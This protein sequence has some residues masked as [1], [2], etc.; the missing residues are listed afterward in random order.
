MAEYEDHD[1]PERYGPIPPPKSDDW[2]EFAP[3]DEHSDKPSDLR[4]LPLLDMARLASHEPPKRQWAVP[5]WIPLLQA[6]Y[7]TGP[8]SAGKSLLTQQ[9]CT[10]KALGGRF[11]GVDVD[12]APALY[13]TCEDDADE[14]ERRQKDIC[15][16]LGT[17]RSALVDKLYLCSLQ[18]EIGNQLVTF[19]GDGQ[20]MLTDAYR[21]LEATAVDLGIRFI[22]L[23]N[24]AHL[25]SEE[26]ERS[27]VAAF[28]NLLNRLSLR[29]GGSVLLL[30][31]PNKMGQ[32]YS[33]STAWENQV[34]S[35]LFMEEPKPDID[36]DLKVLRRAKSNYSRKGEEIEFRWHQGAFVK[37][38]DLP[39][40]EAGDLASAAAAAAYNERFLKCLAEMT[41]QHRHVSEKPGAN[42]A[43]KV[44]ERMSEAKGSSK[45]DMQAA[46][47]RL[48]RLDRIER[49]D[50]WRGPDRKPV[51]GLR[52]TRETPRVA[53]Q[54]LTVDNVS[55]PP[56]P[57]AGNH[58]AD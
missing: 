9:L 32:E 52:E 4:P 33:G 2:R 54:A 56:I 27:K 8:G 12:Q 30:G 42:Y 1:W 50:L 20:M 53:E 19:R 17:P 3:A 11:L 28:V 10:C 48:F 25:T 24:V 58:A 39:P 43:P 37:D 6:T 46:M 31:H 41:R 18:G 55:N 22:V 49:A 47:D 34:R 7:L 44:F 21:R 45:K 15:E 38:A 36:A 40:N 26:I 16:A 23:D 51:F 14:L 35:R 13:V 57:A 5:G 29:I